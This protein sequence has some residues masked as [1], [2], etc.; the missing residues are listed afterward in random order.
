MR[1]RSSILR[2]FSS[3]LSHKNLTCQG[4][5]RRLHDIIDV[6]V[7]GQ[8]KGGKESV[9]F[10]VPA[11]LA[12]TTETEFERTVCLSPPSSSFVTAE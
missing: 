11:E 10:P 7:R 5:N 3:V 12:G 8:E 1:Q 6:I 9:M 4:Y 2:G